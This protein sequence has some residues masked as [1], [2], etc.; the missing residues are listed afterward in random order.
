VIDYLKLMRL[1]EQSE[2]LRSDANNALRSSGATRKEAFD[3]FQ[4][5]VSS[6]VGGTDFSR[7]TNLDELLEMSDESL[8]DRNID[9]Q[10]LRL[11][12]RERKR[13]EM[14]Y[15]EYQQKNALWQQTQPLVDRLTAYANEV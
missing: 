13:S 9:V 1:Q 11:A 2:R 6:A 3:L 15:A 5:A 8:R 10:R 4:A 12:G 7:T 14:Q